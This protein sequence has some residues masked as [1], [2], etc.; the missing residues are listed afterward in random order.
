MEHRIADDDQPLGYCTVLRRA[1]SDAECLY[2]FTLILRAGMRD[3]R[4]RPRRW[5]CV[6]ANVVK[7][8][9]PDNS[10]DITRDDLDALDERALR[11]ILGNTAM[12]ANAYQDERTARTLAQEVRFHLAKVPASTCPFCSR[13]LPGP[14]VERCQGCGGALGVGAKVVDAVGEEKK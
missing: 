3:V 1:V 11:A 9:S 4:G 6:D 7:A 2:H 14:G 10:D 5:L 12:V 8:E 13:P